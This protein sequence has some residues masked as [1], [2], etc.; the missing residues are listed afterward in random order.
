MTKLQLDL[1]SDFQANLNRILASYRGGTKTPDGLIS[2]QN[3]LEGD[4]WEALM[5]QPDEQLAINLGYFAQRYFQDSLLREDLGVQSDKNI[6]DSDRVR[7]ARGH[8]E[9]AL[10]EDANNLLFGV[11]TY[12]LKAT[13]GISAVLGCLVGIQGQAGPVFEW[14][15]LWDSR[16]AYLGA[17][18]NDGDHWVSPLMGEIPNAVILSRWK[19]L[20]QN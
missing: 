17:L 9:R 15:G 2:I 18:G 12:E 4:G 5:N 1:P 3:W 13:N 8:L 7:W 10:Q 20:E 11:H 19:D 16:D 6:S 14:R